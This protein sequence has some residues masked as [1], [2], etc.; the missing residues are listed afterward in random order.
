MFEREYPGLIRVQIAPTPP[1]L[2]H[3]KKGD[4]N[5]YFRKLIQNSGI[6]CTTGL[7]VHGNYPLPTHSSYSL[8][9]KSRFSCTIF[10]KYARLSARIFSCTG[11]E[12]P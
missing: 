9:R 8:E 6:F 1:I 11:S 12:Y 5:V 7:K 3:K 2:N 4:Y 10:L